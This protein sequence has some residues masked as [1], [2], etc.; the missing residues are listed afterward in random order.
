[1]RSRIGQA[2]LCLLFLSMTGLLIAQTTVKGQISPGASY[3]LQLFRY[4]LETNKYKHD[5]G[6]SLSEE[7]VF[8]FQ[9]PSEPNLYKLS[10]SGKELVFIND[11][12]TAI[13][14]NIN[15]T[16]SHDPFSITG[17]KSTSQYMDY[18]S[19]VS[20]LQDKYLNPLGPK[21]EAALKAKDEK[22][23]AQ[24]EKL[25]KK[26]LQLFVG[27]LAGKISSMGSSLA[28]FGIVN[29]L[30]F[31][32]YLSFIEQCHATFVKERPNSPFTSKLGQLIAASKRTQ[33]GNPAPEIILDVVGAKSQKLSDYRGKVVLL[34]FW[35]S[36]CLPCR[37]E[38]RELKKVYANYHKDGFSIWS[39]SID[40]KEEA[41][42]KALAKDDLPWEQSLSTNNNAENTYNVV[43]LPTNF[44]IDKEGNIIAKNLTAQE[45]SVFLEKEF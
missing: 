43:S 21:M 7:G 5:R 22:Q 10:L 4:E 20:R 11:G 45:V 33:I 39:V 3:P 17:S 35:A 38:N 29:T 31:N 14:I 42:K 16:N 9:I 25:H 41:W 34:D 36:W 44:L 27:E 13:T 37:K 15:L 32:K 26:N 6:L 24:I 23:I 18:F 8:H 19:T 2:L 28:V 30:D 12:D 40:K 1:M